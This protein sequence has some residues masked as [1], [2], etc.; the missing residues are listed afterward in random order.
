M[1]ADKGVVNNEPRVPLE[2]RLSSSPSSSLLSCMQ[3]PKALS[4][5]DRLGGASS[6]TLEN[7]DATDLDI[8]EEED[9]EELPGNKRHPWKAHG[10]RAGKKHHKMYPGEFLLKAPPRFDKD[11][12]GGGNGGGGR[13]FGSSIMPS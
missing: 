13:A 1:V 9:M 6:S 2:Q 11:H 5:A 10:K 8:D 7:E 3:I 12:K 4:L